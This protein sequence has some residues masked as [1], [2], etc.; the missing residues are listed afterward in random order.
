MREVEESRAFPYTFRGMG[1]SSSTRL[2]FRAMGA[3]TRLCRSH[4]AGE[5]LY[6][7]GYQRTGLTL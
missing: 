1:M 5:S 7:Y 6:G 4:C 3:G 2:M